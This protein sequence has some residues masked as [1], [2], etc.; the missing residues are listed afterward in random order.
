ML[1]KD[2]IKHL[3]G[4]N[5]PLNQVYGVMCDLHGGSHNLSFRKRSPRAIFLTISQEASQNDINKLMDLSSM[6]QLDNIDFYYQ[7]DTDEE[8][9]VRSIFWS[10]AKSRADYMCFGD[11]ITFDRTYKC[12][13]YEMPVGLFVGVNNQFQCCLFGCVVLRQE[14]TG[15]S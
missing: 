11:A 12:N 9:R 1:L 13:L 2:G 14:T 5:I 4:N 15:W 3:R 8:R 7:V 6:S 10:H